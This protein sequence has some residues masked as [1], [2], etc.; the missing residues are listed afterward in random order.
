MIARIT[1]SLSARLLGIF[2]LTSIVYAF[3]SRAAVDLVLDRDYLRE[4]IGAHMALH[5]NYVLRD[6]GYPPSLGRAQALVDSNPIDIRIEGPDIQW[7]SDE[8][9]P[10]LD[11]L[12]FEPSEFV[13]GMA[14]S[15]ADGQEWGL[16]VAELGFSRHNRH[17]YTQV[18][19]GDYRIVVVTP[20]IAEMP[21]P[22]LA[23]PVIGLISVLVLAACYIAVRWLVSPITWIKAGADRIGSGDLDHR[24]KIVR[25]DELGELTGEINK[26]ADDVQE[27]LEAKR[28]LLLAISHE[29]RSPLTRTKVALELMDDEAT[30][31][32]VLEDV[33]E[34]ERLIHDLLEG[35]QLNT[36]HAPLQRSEVDLY[37]MLKQLVGE[38]FSRERD[39]IDVRVPAQSVTAD[40][41]VVRMRLLVKN[42]LTNAL[43]HS[44]KSVPPVQLEVMNVGND[45][46]IRVR[47]HGAGMTPADAVRATEPFYRADLSRCRDTGG[48]G[49]GLYLCRRIAEAHGGRLE[50]DSEEGKG[51]TVAVTVPRRMD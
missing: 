28:Q 25:N 46:M 23:W 44:P 8:G 34:M 40:V 17:S 32:H 22:N 2:L 39:R 29:L 41:D 31:E 36:R 26:M 47:D 7:V 5:T 27:M 49:L 51:T 9:F 35:E 12:P 13:E 1:R 45:A 48:L 24:I 16:P 42:L 43:C 37:S 15:E 14:I 50:I 38:E 33:E 4:I 30:R 6:L 18:T 3:A 19:E 11:T 10:E 21:P 20:K